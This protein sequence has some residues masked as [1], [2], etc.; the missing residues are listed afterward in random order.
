MAQNNETHESDLCG[1]CRKILVD[2]YF[3]VK[4]GSILE[5]PSF[6]EQPGSLRAVGNE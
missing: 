6:I 2:R 3:R 1:D 4:E 5:I